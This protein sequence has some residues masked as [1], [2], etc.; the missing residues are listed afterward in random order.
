[1]SEQPVQ[2]PETPPPPVRFTRKIMRYFLTGV[3][4]AGPIALTLFLAWWVIGVVD[5]WI[6]PLIP[7]RFN[8]DN[9]LPFALP[10]LGLVIAFVGL[11]LIG[12]LATNLVGRSIVHVGGVILSRVPVLS[13]L[14]GAL[15]QIFETVVNQGSKNFRQVGLIEF[16]RKGLWALVFISASAK[17][18]IAVKA[19]GE[20]IVACFMPT[21]PNPTSGFLVF[22]PRKDVLI[23]DMSVED[24]AKV[25]ISAGLVMP[26]YQKKT[27]ALAEAALREADQLNRP[28]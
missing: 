7:P 15:K 16:P 21:T 25:V 26:E 10:G 13:T 1:M 20:D 23:L 11:T 4:A 3:V 24:G 6:K 14:Y 12:C 5:R 8:P 9:Y 28:E 17:G 18:E 2:P 19:E 27:A 22:V